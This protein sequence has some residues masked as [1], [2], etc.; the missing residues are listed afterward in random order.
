MMCCSKGEIYDGFYY[1][2]LL[3]NLNKCIVGYNIDQQLPLFW[4]CPTECLL[5]ITIGL[6]QNDMFL[7]MLHE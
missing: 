1:L 4:G 5:H 3:E 2:W 6:D 7:W